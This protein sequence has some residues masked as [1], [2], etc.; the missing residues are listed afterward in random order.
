[1]KNVK[2][3]EV[4]QFASI[5]VRFYRLRRFF[6]NSPTLAMGLGKEGS[7]L[8]SS[9]DP[10][11]RISE[12]PPHGQRIRLPPYWH[13]LY[14]LVTM[15]EFACLGIRFQFYKQPNRIFY[16]VKF[17]KLSRSNKRYIFTLFAASHVHG[18]IRI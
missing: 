8:V 15:H 16:L 2:K 14:A 11:V 17:R 13:E 12:P 18:A 4:N 5:A 10:F 7:Y 1:M 3:K 6:I 9:L